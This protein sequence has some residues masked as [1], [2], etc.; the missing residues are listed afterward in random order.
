MNDQQVNDR[1]VNDQLVNDKQVSE[2]PRNHLS[3]RDLTTW[4][5]ISKSAYAGNLRFVRRRV[6]P[7]VEISAVV[8]ANGYGHGWEIIAQLAADHG[9]GSFCVHSL[10]EALQLRQAGHRQDILLLG[11]VMRRRLSEVVQQGLT[12][13]IFDQSSAEALATTCRKLQRAAK[14][15]LKIET[16]T[17]RQ[18]LCGDELRGVVETLKKEPLI[19]IEG[20]YTH[21]ANIEDTTRHDYAEHQKERFR[22]ALRQLRDLGVEPR[23]VHTACSAAALLFTDTHYQMVRLGI[24]QYGFWPSRETQVSY[25]LQQGTT[26]AETLQPLLTWKTRVGQ[27]KPIPADS[28]IGYGCTYQVTRPSRLAIL[29]IGYSDGY[30][31]RLSNRGHVL[32]RGRRA[33][34]RGRICMNLTMVDITDIPDVA[35]EDEVVL[36]GRQGQQDIRAEDLAQHIGTIQ[37]EVVSRLRPGIPRFVV[38]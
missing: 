6:G 37:Y 32:I 4:I 26:G 29:P 19:D 16:G 2:T 7:D 12:L 24:S 33:P 18:G 34:I 23:K 25:Q 21:Y 13:A 10:E 15:H 20:A 14:V 22:S 8:K 17:H 31:R 9:A 11:Q 28:F 1:L 35:P 30:D 38:P 27:V 5:E 36:L 3:S